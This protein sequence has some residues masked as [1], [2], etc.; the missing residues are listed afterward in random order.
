[1]RRH[2]ISRTFRW[3][4]GIDYAGAI[5]DPV[6]AA[7]AG[8][9]V[10]TGDFGEY[11]SA[12]VI[13]HESLLVETVYAHLSRINV[14][15]GDCVRNQQL[16]GAIG[17]SGMSSSTHLHFEVRAAVDPLGFLPRRAR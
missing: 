2:P 17:N 1:M 13:S 14:K 3:H 8:K 7:A 4:R 16:I 6:V 12:I 15:V 5:G 10:F 11:G 9:V